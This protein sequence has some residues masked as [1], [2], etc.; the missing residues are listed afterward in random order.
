MSDTVSPSGKK[1]AAAARLFF[2]AYFRDL[3]RKT[4]NRTI[5]ELDLQRQLADE[6]L[7]DKD[8]QD[9]ITE[10]R[11]TETAYLRATRTKLTLSE[12]E[13]VRMIG[14]GG[15]GEVRLVRHVA[16]EKLLALKL[17]SKNDILQRGYL[18]QILNEREVMSYY[19]PF[20]VQ[21]HAS[22]TTEK[23]LCLLMDFC[24][25]GDLMALLIRDNIFPE[26]QAKFYAA[27]IVEA[28]DA[29]HRRS[30]IHRDLK[31]DNILIDADGHIKLA[32]FGLA[33]MG[34]APLRPVDVYLGLMQ[35]KNFEDKNINI[36][37]PN[38][39]E[40][41]STRRL[42]AKSVV[43]TCDFAAPEVLL[44]KEYTHAAD[45][46]SLGCI[47]FE[48]LVGYCPF[49]AQTTLETCKK[50][51]NWR[52]TLHF[53]P[54]KC[55][56]VAEDLIRKLLCEEHVRLGGRDVN[57]IRNH[58]FFSGIEWRSLKLSSAPWVP[59]LSDD[60]DTRYFDDFSSV[61]T[62][63]DV[64]DGQSESDYFFKGFSYRSFESVKNLSSK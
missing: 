4:A 47:I 61:D 54:G 23:H 52:R 41:G 29:C 63:L 11:S 36:S 34:E 58:P 19:S 8:R 59:E 5:R 37:T 46:W 27:E 51:V 28:L 43:G 16:S 56:P 38:Q 12:F 44:R 13:T 33:T 15:F 40:T 42:R 55:S 24:S 6:T 30:V 2:D 39:K 22:F 64:Q 32:D 35:E 7:S 21:L 20:L 26:H 25:G 9:L 18:A 62:S 53:P 3:S 10:F 49:W 57:E 31:P 17:I 1:R 50:I 14:K 45:F 48:M 60:V